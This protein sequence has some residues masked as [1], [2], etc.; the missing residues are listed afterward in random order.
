MVKIIGHM[1][2]RHINTDNTM[3]LSAHPT[4]VY[5][6]YFV[7]ARSLNRNQTNELVRQNTG[8]LCTEVF[9]WLFV[10]VHAHASL[11]SLN[12]C[13]CV[14]PLVYGLWQCR[15]VSLSPS[16]AASVDGLW[17][18]H[19][20]KTSVENLTSEMTIGGRHVVLLSNSALRSCLDSHHSITDHIHNLQQKISNF[21]FSHFLFCI[22]GSVTREGR[23]RRKSFQ[24]SAV[25]I[26]Y[27]TD[28]F[29]PHICVF[30]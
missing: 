11:C 18:W 12:M 28:K 1:H 13:K 3:C 10:S 30:A 9:A 22:D 14:I 16:I 25:L 2:V 23:K 17:I 4:H 26:M 27:T 8:L 20:A 29:Y 19:E 21:L 15:W 7:C 24:L 5:W 6:G